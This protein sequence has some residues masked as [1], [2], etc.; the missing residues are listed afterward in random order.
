MLN[1]AR[2]FLGK[3]VEGWAKIEPAIK[4]YIFSLLPSSEGL[5]SEQMQKIIKYAESRQTLK[6]D[7]VNKLNFLK[8]VG[9]FKD[10]PDVKDKPEVDHEE[11]H[12]H[13]SKRL[14]FNSD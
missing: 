9:L 12:E 8:H 11:V 1:T 3:N 5:S 7:N 10:K 13:T 2:S 6:K 4:A 14:K